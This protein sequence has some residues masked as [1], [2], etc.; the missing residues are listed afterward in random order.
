MRVI[1]IAELVLLTLVMGSGLVWIYQVTLAAWRRAPILFSERGLLAAILLAGAVGFLVPRLFDTPAGDSLRSRGESPLRYWATIVPAAILGSVYVYCG[2][3][4]LWVRTYFLGNCKRG[5]EETLFA[6]AGIALGGVTIGPRV[7][8]PVHP[9]IAV[10]LFFSETHQLFGLMATFQ[11]SNEHA[12]RL[13]EE[14]YRMAA[15]DSPTYVRS[16][17]RVGTT[18]LA[19]LFVA[20]LVLS[21]IALIV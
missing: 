20:A 19:G 2:V 21:Y 18:I 9:G 1:D 3:K 7:T 8:F 6:K 15:S 5:V 10:D 17:S 14:A 16:Y 12:R 4:S 13:A 11:T